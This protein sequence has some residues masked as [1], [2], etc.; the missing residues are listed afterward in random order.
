[1]SRPILAP[2]F[3]I[4]LLILST[5]HAEPDYTLSTELRDRVNLATDIYL[6][7]RIQQSDAG[8]FL[9]PG[10]HSDRILSA[11]RPDRE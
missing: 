3:A 2:L 11:Q 7:V 10:E 9:A 8:R 5:V 4:A 6:P 1:M